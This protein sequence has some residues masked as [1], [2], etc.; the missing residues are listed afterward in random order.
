MM[1]SWRGA[2]LRHNM[3]S[4][5]SENFLRK[6]EP[7]MTKPLAYLWFGLTVVLITVATYIALSV[8]PPDADQGNVGRILYYHLPNWVAM[9]LCFLANLVAS[10]TYLASRNRS[11]NLA[12]MADAVAVS[13]A[14]VGL[15]FCSLGLITGS[16][17]GRAVWGI[18]W[19]WDARL[20]ATLVLWLMYVAYLVL[21]KVST[22]GQSRTLAAV[23]AIF[24]YCDV[25]IVYMS[26]RW[27]RTQH[28]APVFF[29]GPDAGV[30]PKMQPAVTWSIYA[31]LAWAVLLVGLRIAIER[32]RQLTAQAEVAEALQTIV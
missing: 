14:E 23:L 9:S 25:P 13:T 19:T 29:G 26:T 30:D 17:W 5:H 12:L 24:A 16:I 28:P 6:L 3:A 10:V 7:A 15:V 18:W 22:G 1:A 4:S 2:G 8:V 32:R 31:W 21:R 11:A 20:T 27:W